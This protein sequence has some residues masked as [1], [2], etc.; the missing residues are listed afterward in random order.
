MN[1]SNKA[2]NDAY[3]AWQR[4]DYALTSSL[5]D[6]LDSAEALHLRGLAAR[7]LGQRDLARSSLTAAR[8]KDPGN[9]EIHHNFALLELDAEAYDQALIAVTQALELRPNWTAALRTQGRTFLALGNWRKADAV[10]QYLVDQNATDSVARYGLA[11]VWLELGRAEEALAAFDQLLAEGMTDPSC[12][13][14]RARAHQVLGHAQRARTDF[15]LALKLQPSV[16]FLRETARHLWTMNKS[17]A[18]ERLLLQ[19]YNET[20]LQLCAAELL[21]QGGSYHLVSKVLSDQPESAEALATRAWACIEQDRNEQAVELSKQALSYDQKHARA[22]AAIITALCAIDQAAAAQPHIDEM[23]QRE[24]LAQHWIAYQLMVWRLLDNP[25]YQQWMDYEDLI[26][27]YELPL[28]DGYA[29]ILDFNSQLETALLG[30]HNLEQHPIDQS[31]RGG[32]QTRR[33]L[34]LEQAPAIT[35]YLKAIDVPI[36]NYMQHIGTQADHPLCARNTGKYKIAGCWSV[37]L[38]GG[39][40]HVNH[41]HPEGWIS[42]AYYVTV[43]AS[44]EKTR[45]GWINFGEPAYATKPASPCERSIQ[46]VAGQLVLFPSYLWHGTNPVIG[47]E[48]RLTAPFDV[49]PA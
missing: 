34:E 46:P 37:K 20:S 36:Q 4:G 32:S 25:Q 45:S 47:D 10:Y 44:D 49:V 1:H 24:P 35:A 43:P 33:D 5:L 2:F 7:R 9:A 8:V 3:N 41:V 17:A 29:S 19:P 22:S 11:N 6:G 23:R 40:H 27:I 15:E 48:L 30:L 18:F 16:L 14:M 38:N 28:P 21:R 42:S 12:Y 26:Q 39:G 13:F 31:L